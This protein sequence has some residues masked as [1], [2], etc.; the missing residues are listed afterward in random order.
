MKVV[1][2]G[3]SG[4]IGSSLVASL[5][6]DGHD[7]VTLVR[8]T[9]TAA[10]QVQWD[11][12]LGASGVTAELRAAIDGAG[13]VVNLAGA[14]VAEKR[15]D[16]A[17]K[18]QILDSRV[19]AT[20]CLATAITDVASKPPVFV[21][22]SASG[23]YGDTGPVAA[24]ESAHAGRTFLAHVCQSWE[25][26]AEPARE[27]G[28]RVVHPRTGTVADPDGGA[29]G[30]WL[31]VFKLGGGG[32][33]G[34]GKQWW[35]LISLTDEVR[36]IRHAIDTDSLVGPA[37]FAAPEQVT[38]GDLAKALGRALSR[39]S[40]V[41]APL[42]GLRIVLGEFADELVISQRMAPN[43]LTASGFEFSHPTIASIVEDMLG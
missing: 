12:S 33:L 35:S 25:L 18:H 5:Q 9:P 13:A 40:L 1:V 37:N 20:T 31:P 11:P 3:S 10:G 24:D 15:W 27:V 36:G 30:R 42:F 34:N 28:V 8:R 19:A 7:V 39:P 16:E 38:N 32:P 43:A 6:A 26:A 41:P 17:W 14:G 23:Y 4:L 29:F 2:S 22:G 21:S